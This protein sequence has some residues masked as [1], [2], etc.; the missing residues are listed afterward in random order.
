MCGYLAAVGTGFTGVGIAE[1]QLGIAIE[2]ESV[3]RIPGFGGCCLAVGIGA[4]TD[5]PVACLC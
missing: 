5:A 4:W 2:G 3:G 1:H